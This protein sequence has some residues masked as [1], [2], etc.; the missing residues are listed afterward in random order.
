MT[1]TCAPFLG[2]LLVLLLETGWG[3][4]RSLG[5]LMVNRNPSSGNVYARAD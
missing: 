5:Q 2:T 4:S 1:G 3:Y